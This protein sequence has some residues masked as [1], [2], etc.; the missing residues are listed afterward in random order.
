MKL[1]K[2][3]G[4]D[5]KNFNAIKHCL[6]RFVVDSLK[7]FFDS[8][9]QGGVFL[10]LAKITIVSPVFK[11]RDIADTLVYQIIVQSQFFLLKFP[12]SC[13]N[14]PYLILSDYSF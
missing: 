7:Y 5:E 6:E 4:T 8:S 2:S 10:E 13:L 11:T 14:E 9:L 1:N 3:H 12:P